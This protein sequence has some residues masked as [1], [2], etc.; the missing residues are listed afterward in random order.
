VEVGSDV[1]YGTVIN[2]PQHQNN[3]SLLVIPIAAQQDT[4]YKCIETYN[5]R[6][7][8]DISTEFKQCVMVK[9]ERKL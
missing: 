8:R 4:G 7:Y 2:E 9:T 6:I 1:L 3:T 5:L